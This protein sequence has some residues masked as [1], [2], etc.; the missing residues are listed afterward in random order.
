MACTCAC[1][2]NINSP[3]VAPARHVDT[4]PCTPALPAL[5]S[6]G[7]GRPGSQQGG[8]APRPIAVMEEGA[9]GDSDD[10]VEVSG[11]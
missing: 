11:R 4:V 9:R 1:L 8:A 10:D 3:H 2:P 6:A 7:D 5:L